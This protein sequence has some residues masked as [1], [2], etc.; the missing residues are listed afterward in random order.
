MLKSRREDQT[1]IT[2]SLNFA[3]LTKVH[4]YEIMSEV[5]CEK[6]EESSRSTT[7]RWKEEERMGKTEK[8]SK[9]HSVHPSLDHTDLGLS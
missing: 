5:G 9:L 3:A 1:S 4:Q 8:G 7:N 2:R 6:Q